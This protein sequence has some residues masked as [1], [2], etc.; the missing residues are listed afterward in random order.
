MYSKRYVLDRCYIHPTQFQGKL[1]LF[2]TPKNLS[3][4]GI[5]SKCLAKN[6]V[7]LEDLCTQPW[8]PSP[9]K[10]EHRTI[11]LL[12]IYIFF[13]FLQLQFFLKLNFQELPYFSSYNLI[14]FGKVFLSQALLL[15]TFSSKF[16]NGLKNYEIFLLFILKIQYLR[17]TSKWLSNKYLNYFYNLYLLQ[18]NFLYI[19]HSLVR[20]SLQRQL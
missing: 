10:H 1:F 19:F 11:T 4:L 8:T 18:F 5:N 14:I 3:S 20:W 16:R 17:E 9:N 7:N 15:L 6:F 13:F 12:L 2:H